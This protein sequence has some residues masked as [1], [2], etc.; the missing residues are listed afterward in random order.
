MNLSSFVGSKQQRLKIVDLL[1]SW[2]NLLFCYCLNGGSACMPFPKVEKRKR[3]RL[4]VL[5]FFFVSLL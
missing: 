2:Y 3:V 5:T 1:L 4:L